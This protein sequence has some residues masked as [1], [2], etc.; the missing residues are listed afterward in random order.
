MM[1]IDRPNS[2]SALIREIISENRDLHVDSRL[3]SQ[4]DYHRICAFTTDTELKHA[5]EDNIQPNPLDINRINIPISEI[6][7][8][9]SKRNDLTFP[10]NPINC[11]YIS[12]VLDYLCSDVLELAGS[13]AKNAGDNL[14]TP[15]HVK[16]AIDNVLADILQPALDQL[17]PLSQ[18]FDRFYKM[19][20]NEHKQL[21]VNKLR[22]A[23][24]NAGILD[25]DWKVLKSYLQIDQNGNI[26]KQRFSQAFDPK[27][28]Y[29]EK[30]MTNTVEAHADLLWIGRLELNA[31]HS[32]KQLITKILSK[33]LDLRIECITD[34]I[35]NLAMARNMYDITHSTEQIGDNCVLNGD[36]CVLKERGLYGIVFSYLSYS[37]V[38]N[39]VQ[40]G[41]GNGVCAL[42]P[43]KYRQYVSTDM[44]NDALV[45]ILGQCH[46]G[47]ELRK[48]T[49]VLLNGLM[50]D[51]LNRI[52]LKIE[53]DFEK[54]SDKN[55][56]E[57]EIPDLTCIL[58]SIGVE[59]LLACDAIVYIRT[60]VSSVLIDNIFK[61]KCV[62]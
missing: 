43:H 47:L 57:Y 7:S 30:T 50:L 56:I 61:D 58:R 18:S 17:Y 4:Q 35:T 41:Y 51:L 37:D 28:S 36:N 52:V 24:L 8:Y 44:F 38:L 14:L 53:C 19:F 1:N 10:L 22:A 62:N 40:A 49:V 34:N 26:D 23:A 9:L 3:V 45:K 20:A 21:S 46:R 29:R 59:G 13:K 48:D 27:N 55:V 31:K 2:Q 12:G 33:E 32:E 11:M 25:V 60:I 16:L 5:Q 39:G 6:K 15:W 42:I 54:F